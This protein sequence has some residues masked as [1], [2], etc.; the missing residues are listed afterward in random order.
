MK[1]K[2][3]K[4][5]YKYA[6][7]IIPGGTTLFSKRSEIHLP[8]KWPAYF[9]KSKNINVWDLNG[10]KYL[11]MFCAVGTSILGYSNDKVNN[12]VQNNIIKGNLTTLNCPE[13]VLLAEQIIKHH[14]WASMAKFTRGGGEA[15]A[16]AI[17]I[18]RSC[19]KNKNVAFCGYHGWHDWYLSSN[20]NS[21]N[22][23]DQHLMSGLNYDGIPENLKN[24]SFPFPYNNFEY[25]FKLVK[26]KNIGIIK[27]EVMRNIEP[28]NNYLQKIRKLC[29]EKK[30]ILIFDECTSGYREN[31]GGIHLRFKVNPD[32]AIFGKA[33]GSGYAINAIIG[34]RKIMQKAENTFISSTFWGERIGYTAALSTIREFKR[35]NVFKKIEGNGKLI[36][37]VWLD[38]SKKYNV[39]IKIMGTNAIPSFEFNNNHA[40]RKTFLTQEMLNNKILA[41]NMVYITIFH[42][43]RNIRKYIKILD[44][45]FCDISKKNIK[46]ILKSKICFKPI[47]RIN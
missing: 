11:D 45:V 13:E 44:K 8:N 31:M 29:N 4:D 27:M 39:K 21:K 42:N 18:A 2:N 30:I 20:I 36:K 7:L 12:S 32:I 10:V 3:N 47:N 34:K 33:L 19:T 22:N 24:T 28:Q 15:N 40:E 41:T 26:K 5:L 6:K 1:I 16:V 38:V 14:T 35:L 43:K 25:L 17:R 37:S 23:L 9:S 46:H